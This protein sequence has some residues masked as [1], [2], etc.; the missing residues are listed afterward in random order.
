[1][2]FHWLY[3]KPSFD[4]LGAV[5]LIIRLLK[6]FPLPVAAFFENI[7]WQGLFLQQ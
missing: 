6:I 1:M 7:S 3:F 2:L 5:F 4:W